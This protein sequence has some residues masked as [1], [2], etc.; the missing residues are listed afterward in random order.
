[1]DSHIAFSVTIE[2]NILF[3]PDRELV[4]QASLLLNFSDPWFYWKIQSKVSII[5]PVH[6]SISFIWNT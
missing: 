1:M 4:T 6:L 5:R 3:I 2:T